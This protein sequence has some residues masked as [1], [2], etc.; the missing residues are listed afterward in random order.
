MS[1]ALDRILEEVRQLSPDERRQLRER[2]N[3]EA[4][5]TPSPVPRDV[6]AERAALITS[7]R[8]KYAHVPTSSEAF[9]QRKQEEIELEDR[10]R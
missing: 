5:I 2:L 7:V 1:Q 10:R 6:Q 4:H 9:N 8:G 3:Y